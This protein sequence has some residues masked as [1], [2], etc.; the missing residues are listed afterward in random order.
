MRTITASYF[1]QVLTDWALG[2]LTESQ[3]HA[4][5]EDRFC[6]SSYECE[7]GAANEVLSRLDMMD[8]NPLTSEDIPVLLDALSSPEYLSMLEKYEQQVD[9]SARRT[10]LRHVQLLL[11]LTLRPNNSFKP[12]PWQR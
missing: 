4:W 10:A 9:I 6:T 2:N 7:S 8:M 11:V 3:V 5:A 1:R 12:T